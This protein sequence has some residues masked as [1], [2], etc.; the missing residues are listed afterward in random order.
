MRRLGIH[1]FVWTDGR[2]QDG[3]EKALEKSAE[4]G[5]RAIEFAYLQPEKFDLDRLSQKAQSL[6]I[7]IGV[8]I[9]LP[10]DADVS[11]EDESVVRRGE[12]MLADIVRAG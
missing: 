5:Y 3:L 6:D 11:S 10:L 9:G 1:S 12:S 7:E 4:H 8:T 2:T